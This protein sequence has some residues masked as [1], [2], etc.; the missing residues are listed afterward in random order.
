MR[1]GC[2]L[3]EWM[4]PD[5]FQAQCGDAVG[6][7]VLACDDDV[8]LVLPHHQAYGARMFQAV[9]FWHRIYHVTGRDFSPKILASVLTW[10]S[11]VGTATL[12]VGIRLNSVLITDCSSTRASGAPRQTWMPCPK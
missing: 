5:L 2:P 1:S 11:S 9:G 12:R 4:A 10:I 3:R 7:Q 8:G 6:D